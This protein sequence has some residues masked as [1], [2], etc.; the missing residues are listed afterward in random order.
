MITTLGWTTVLYLATRRWSHQR[1]SWQWW[2]A[3]QMSR[4][5]DQAESIRDDVLQQTFA[6]R[7][8]LE[9]NL[10]DQPDVAQTEQWLDR[11]QTFYQTLEQLSNQLS[12]PFVADSLPLAL[13]FMVKT[14]Q[15]NQPGLQVQLELPSNWPDDP[16]EHNRVILSTVTGILDLLTSV[17]T[18]E[19]H[20]TLSLDHQQNSRTLTFTH[21]RH[22]A[23]DVSPVN[24]D[25][26]DNFNHLQEIFCNLI[27][28]HLE[29][30]RDGYL[31]TGRLSWEGD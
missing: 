27:T 6:F 16:S 18:N 1:R 2:H 17:D 8:Y 30:T 9:N 26:L 12:P 5:H 29:I 11:F 23:E 13:Q 7:R 22:R 21:K 31:V 15:H 19:Q 25:N 3:H 14:W 4:L 10:A 28:G 20:L 24:L